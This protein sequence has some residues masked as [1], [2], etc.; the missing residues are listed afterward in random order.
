[1][2]GV[3]DALNAIADVGLT[4]RPKPKTKAAKR[5]KRLRAKNDKAKAS[6]K[7]SGGKYGTGQ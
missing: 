6:N 2:K 4:Y 3:P 1:M 5:R 7:T